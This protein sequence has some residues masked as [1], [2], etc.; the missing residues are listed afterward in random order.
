D[1]AS[2]LAS[3]APRHP[4]ALHRR[5]ALLCD[6]L[7]DRRALPGLIR[8]VRPPLLR[9]DGKRH[10][11]GR[12]PSLRTP[13]LDG[14]AIAIVSIR[15]CIGPGRRGLEPTIPPPTFRRSRP[16]ATARG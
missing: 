11:E 6:L 13:A 15:T 4:R 12:S 14:A 9:S 8:A 2:P 10:A 7:R 1:R 16:R 5:N 3:D